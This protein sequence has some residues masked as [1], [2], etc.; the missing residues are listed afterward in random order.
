MARDANESC[1]TGLQVEFNQFVSACL[2]LCFDAI[3][4]FLEAVD[5]NDIYSFAEEEISEE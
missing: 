1:D 4:V 2:W 3:Q 5:Q